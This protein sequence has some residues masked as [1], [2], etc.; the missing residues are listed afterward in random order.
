MKRKILA[1]LAMLTFSISAFAIN[2]TLHVKGGV[3]YPDA[4]DKAGF[5]SAA[6]LNIGVDKYFTLGAESGFGWVKWE[7]KDSDVAAGYVT[8]SKVD[9]TNAYTLPLLAVATVRLADMM[10]TYGF[11]PY[12]TGGAGYSWTWYDNPEFSDRFEGFT[13]QV[14]GGVEIKIGADSNLSFLI[15]GG[16]R[17][18]GVQ[19]SD[20]Y[21]LDMSGFIGR[22]GI[23]FP[24]EVTE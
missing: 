7:D 1:T 11:M 24:L 10:E 3:Q 21:E 13:W 12:L 14:M 22:V 6:T 16:Y 8:L 20:D 19:N 23:S 15:E 17:D 4:P 5:D 18:A 9:K 2:S